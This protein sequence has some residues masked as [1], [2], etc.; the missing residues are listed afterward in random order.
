MFDAVLAQVI[1]A[2][3]TIVR[4]PQSGALPVDAADIAVAEGLGRN[5]ESRRVT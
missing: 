5:G 4:S 1:T 3:G 2:D